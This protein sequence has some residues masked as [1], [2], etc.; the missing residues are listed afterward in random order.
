MNVKLLTYT[1]DPEK[2]VAAAAKLCY[3]KSEIGT[4]MD[5]LTDE[6]VCEFLDRLSNLGH[7]YDGETEVLTKDG[8][9]KWPDANEDTEFATVDPKNRNFVGFEKATQLFNYDY[10]GE[11]VKISHHDVDLLVTNGHKIYASVSRGSK[12]RVCPEYSL[13]PTNYTLN[14]GKKVWESPF[15][16]VLSAKNSNYE[17]SNSDSIYKLYGFFIGDGYAAENLDK[18]SICFHLKKERKITYL[19]NVCNELGIELKCNANN[20]Y[21]IKT[22]D[23]Y[24]GKFRNMFYN[25]N[26]DKTFPISFL[27]M[28]SSQFNC[29]IDGLLNSDG[30]YCTLGKNM[31]YSTCSM[32]LI[33]RL[34]AL[35][36]INNSN[37]SYTTAYKKDDTRSS[38]YR[39]YFYKEK[40]LFP[41]I[42]DSRTCDHAN[43]KIV[44]YSG[45]V[46]CASVSTG[47]LVVRR[48]GKVCLCGNCSPTEHASFTFGIEGVSRSFLAQ[49]S[50]HR[51][52]SL[53]VQSQRYV[54][55]S[56]VGSV[57]P[58]EIA[59]STAVSD[60]FN[61]AINDAFYSYNDIKNV[62]TKKYV[63]AGMTE[64]DAKKKAQED[65]RYVLP[66]ACSTK[67]I[68]TMN[69]RELNH[70][71]NLRCCNRAQWEIRECAEK[72]LA[73]VYPV[74]PHLFKNAGPSCVCGACPEGSM[75]CG[76]AKEMRE[77]YSKIKA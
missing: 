43:A 2:I 48:N 5:N 70:F 1:Q 63:D 6:K 20:K 49:I 9:I 74:A 25:K 54:D 3:S 77:K 12:L 15:R 61:D 34:Q 29:F 42:N 32:E 68:I 58:P 65:A 71:F 41:M 10:S 75:S 23:I 16:L 40:S 72:M 69:A 46:Y 27:T 47:L 28:T 26:G 30:H 56:T 19:R 8:F 7:C 33:D 76:K 50:R 35:C 62:L 13:I 24:S 22:D 37:C 44:D 11:M 57:T 51:I 18:S 60:L 45:K 67:M 17:S 73:L 39:V 59:E 53:S 52:A 4:L 36:S 64:R 38:C 66:E 14:T 31:E 55:M 21:A